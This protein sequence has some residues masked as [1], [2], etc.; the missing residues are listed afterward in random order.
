[1]AGGGAHAVGERGSRAFE[2]LMLRLYPPPPVVM[3]MGTSVQ[4]NGCEWD[5]VVL[6]SLGPAN[7]RALGRGLPVAVADLHSTG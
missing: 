5:R 3:S 4:V 7:S 1:M 2:L 6:V